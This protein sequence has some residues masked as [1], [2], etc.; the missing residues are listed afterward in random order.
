MIYV[1]DVHLHIPLLKW[2][3]CAQVALLFPGN[4]VEWPMFCR[5]VDLFPFRQILGSR[6]VLVCST[7]HAE[8]HG[9][10]RHD[11]C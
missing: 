7:S 4:E 6:F 1:I 2:F 5:N 11:H 8:I 3:D 9:K 10:F